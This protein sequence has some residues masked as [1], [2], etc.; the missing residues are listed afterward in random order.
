MRTAYFNQS[1]TPFVEAGNIFIHEGA[2]A[3]ELSVHVGGF[4]FALLAGV[5]ALSL[6]SSLRHI[7]FAT[8]AESNCGSI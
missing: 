1:R 6:L 8:A 7:Q 4:W 2:K 3:A 5:V